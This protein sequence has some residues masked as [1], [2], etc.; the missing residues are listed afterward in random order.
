MPL[1]RGTDG[2]PSP[3]GL[4]RNG[5]DYGV[6]L[7]RSEAT[8]APISHQ[9]TGRVKPQ[10]WDSTSTRYHIMGFGKDGKG[11]ILREARSQALATLDNQAAIII[12]T[13]LAT[14]ERFRIIKSELIASITGLTAGEGDGLFIGLADGDFT[15]GEIEA[16][17]ENNGPLGPND[18]VAEATS[19]R[20]TRWFGSL[21]H[22]VGTEAIFTNK[23]G[24]HI[25]EEVIRWTFAR[26][27]SWNFF[28]Y[29]MGAQLTTGATVLIRAKEFGVWVT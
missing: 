28:V 4:R 6:Q 8:V 15:V 20:F 24:G 26:T 2:G 21:D 19:E 10:G 12:D 5:V 14:L 3:Y 17:I 23:M 22:E 27:K 7:D 16:S 9:P 11:V 13:K 25:M 29:N 18:Q 1:S